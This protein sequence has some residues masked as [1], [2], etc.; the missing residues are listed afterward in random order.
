MCSLRG[1]DALGPQG[2]S[3]AL[4]RFR[5]RQDLRFGI[6]AM[7]QG[8]SRYPGLRVVV[9]TLPCLLHIAWMEL[10]TNGGQREC[11][12]WRSKG[13]ESVI[14]TRAGPSSVFSVKNLLGAAW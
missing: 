4:R 6:R 1:F 11:A 12:V 13:T 10:Q 2:P 7:A 14:A 9:E 3:I 8:W 5:L